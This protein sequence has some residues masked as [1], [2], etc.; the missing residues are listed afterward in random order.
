MPIRYELPP[1]EKARREARAAREDAIAKAKRAHAQRIIPPALANLTRSEARLI[2]DA[3]D[4]VDMGNRD[5]E[6]LDRIAKRLLA[7]MD[8]QLA[9]DMARIDAEFPEVP[10]TSGAR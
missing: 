7:A 1:A 10:T 2:V 5:N 8:V 9:S 6:R 4:R 3:I